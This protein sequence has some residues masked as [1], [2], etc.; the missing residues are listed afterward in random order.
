MTG[1]LIGLAV[2]VV[3]GVWGLAT[4]L[5]VA[6]RPGHPRPERPGIGEDVSENDEGP[7]AS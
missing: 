1:F 6:T 4:W 2:V 7:S 3:L 5:L